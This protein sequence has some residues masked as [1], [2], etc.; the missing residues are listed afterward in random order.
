MTSPSEHR[1]ALS[2]ADALTQHERFDACRC[3]TSPRPD[4]GDSCTDLEHAQT[5]HSAKLTRA[6]ML[7]AV[8]SYASQCAGLLRPHEGQLLV[9]Y[10][11]S[12]VAVSHE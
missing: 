6:A 12:L 3:W 1:S 7:S 10:C 8:A 5:W 9:D 2:A 4:S 11:N